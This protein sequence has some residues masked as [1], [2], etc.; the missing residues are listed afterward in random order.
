MQVFSHNL[1]GVQGVGAGRIGA[2]FAAVAGL[3]I[4][5]S[6]VSHAQTY[7]GDAYGVDRPLIH[8]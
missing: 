2:G 8:V 6:G 5:A 1:R 4:G 3:L 7:V